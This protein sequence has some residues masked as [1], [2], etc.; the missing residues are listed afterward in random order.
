MNS[1]SRI[2]FLKTT[3]LKIEEIPVWILLLI[4]GLLYSPLV[5]LGYGSDSDSYSVVRTGQY[6]V[7]TLD[8]LPSRLPGYFVH[9]VF[10]FFL[11]L[12]G[13]S[14][15]C[16]LGTLG[17]TL[18]MLGAFED[19]CTRL[20]VPS[21]NLLTLTLAIHPFVWANAAA[22]IDYLWAL[23]FAFFGIS[24]LLRK[25][26]LA[27]AITLGLAIGSRLSTVLLVT[28]VFAY[29]LWK[30]KGNR[31]QLV[32]CGFFTALIAA[33][34]YLPALDFLEWDISRWLILST[35]DPNLWTFSLRLG[36]FGYKN[37]MFW[38]LPAI[39]WMIVIVIFTFFHSRNHVK[40]W[41]DGVVGLSLLIILCYEI[42]FYQA[43]IEMEYL[44]PTLPFVLIV[45]GKALRAQP[46]YLLIFF[47]LILIANF[48]WINPARSLTPNQT[49]EVVY[50]LWLEKGYL[51]KDI[52]LRL[53]MLHP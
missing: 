53:S 34:L 50:G 38:S 4:A 12:I 46:E 11:N 19:I 40:S 23:G 2:N 8:Y 21:K 37:L 45:F 41:G 31:K 3:C 15:A 22:T 25:R 1:K 44:L 43:P 16:N 17:M 42:L 47:F 51:L 48:I 49:S 5:F 52:S 6:F 29:L 33:I 32:L 7:Q 39:L 9:E 35:G 26:N 20:N 18:L 10:V 30:Q 28:F 24:L 27:A 36:R 14:I 13:G